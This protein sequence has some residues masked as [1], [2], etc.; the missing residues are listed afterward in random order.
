M[1]SNE[2]L[3]QAHT[4]TCPLAATMTWDSAHAI[5]IAVKTPCYPSG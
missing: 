3:Q 1:T 2:P 4:E 5:R